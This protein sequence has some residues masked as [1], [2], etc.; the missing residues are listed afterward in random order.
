MQGG[1][2]DNMTPQN[3][4]KF[5]ASY[6]AA[7]G[8]CQLVIFEGAEHEW[9]ANPGPNTDRSHETVKAFIARNLGSRAA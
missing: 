3:Q 4:E 6:C 8:E 7:G 9:T 2:D 1:A 5:A